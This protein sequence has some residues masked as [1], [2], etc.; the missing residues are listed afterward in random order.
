MARTGISSG[1]GAERDLVVLVAR[2]A[3]STGLGTPG[4]SRD[5][6]GT[7]NSLAAAPRGYRS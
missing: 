6:L 5:K 7:W 4:S 1:P 3:P 2:A